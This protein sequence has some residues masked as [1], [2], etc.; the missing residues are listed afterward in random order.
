MLESRPLGHSTDPTTIKTSARIE[1]EHPWAE[2]R[3]PDRVPGSQPARVG[4]G[5]LTPRRAAWVLALVACV[6]LLLGLRVLDRLDGLEGSNPLVGSG[7]EDRMFGIEEPTFLNSG[8]VM[9]R[10]RA[11]EGASGYQLKIYDSSL[12][13]LY[14]SPIQ[15]D[16]ILVLPAATIPDPDPILVWR[17][18]AYSGSSAMAE[19]E[20]GSLE[21]R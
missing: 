13:L 14:E 12:K 20:V 7:N 19:S 2:M 11:V 21:P 3:G 10:W 18:I 16:T 9:F 17:V 15:F 8:S 1:R 6:A 4:R 5:I